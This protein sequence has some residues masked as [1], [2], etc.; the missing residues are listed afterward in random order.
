MKNRFEMDEETTVFGDPEELAATING[1]FDAILEEANAE[2]QLP[3]QRH[4]AAELKRQA[5]K[6]R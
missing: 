3:H 2:K 4:L 5:G 6:R 1:R